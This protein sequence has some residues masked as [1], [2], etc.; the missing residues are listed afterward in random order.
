MALSVW[1]VCFR[2][3][4]LSVILDRG[5]KCSSSPDHPDHSC[6]LLLDGY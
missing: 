4:D 1:G 5:K 3:D 2:L 6:G